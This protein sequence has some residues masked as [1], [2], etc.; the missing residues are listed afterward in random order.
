MLELE[1]IMTILDNKS[2]DMIRS[3][4]CTDKWIALCL[5]MYLK[6]QFY[7]HSQASPS[8]QQANGRDEAQAFTIN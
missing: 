4:G 5:Y 3:L 6:L 8:M 2:H 7:D 1:A